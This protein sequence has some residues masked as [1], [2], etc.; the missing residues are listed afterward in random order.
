MLSYL[1]GIARDFPPGRE[2]FFKNGGISIITNCLDSGIDKLVAKALFLMS[3]FYK[4]GSE[5]SNCHVAG[6]CCGMIVS[7]V[8]YDRC[9]EGRVWRGAVQ[10]CEGAGCD[11]QR[12]GCVELHFPSQHCHSNMW[13]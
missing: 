9:N 2:M 5:G 12:S 3:Y 4:T 8:G 10:V 1:L 7:G 11:L 6:W 13:H